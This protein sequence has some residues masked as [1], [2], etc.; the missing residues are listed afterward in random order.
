M[1]IPLRRSLAAGMGV[2]AGEAESTRSGCECNCPGERTRLA[3][4]FRRPAETNFL[5]VSL[6]SAEMEQLEQRFAIA[7]TRSP[8]RETRALP[9]PIAETLYNNFNRVRS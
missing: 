9:R 7:R 6:R 2:Q 8:A 5:L 1:A 3:C 4:W